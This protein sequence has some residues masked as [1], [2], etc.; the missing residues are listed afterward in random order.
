[1]FVSYLLQTP[2]V[3]FCRYECLGA[4]GQSAVFKVVVRDL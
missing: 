4:S 2:Q 1:M 3:F